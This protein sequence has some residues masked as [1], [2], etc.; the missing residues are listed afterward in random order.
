MRKKC[1]VPDSTLNISGAILL[2]IL[3][4]Q[5]TALETKIEGVENKLFE[6]SIND[7]TYKKWTKKF[8]AN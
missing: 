3:K 5:F 2:V 4:N 1:R 8:D 6:E 7:V